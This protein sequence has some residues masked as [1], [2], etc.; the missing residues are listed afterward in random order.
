MWQAQLQGNKSWNLAPTP[1][2]DRQ[3]KSFSFYVEPGDIGRY[4]LYGFLFKIIIK[5]IFILNFILVLIDTRVWYHSTAIM[6][7]E[8]SLTI[9][10][11]YG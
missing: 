5:L 8:F 9:Q 11:E 6:N 7:G 3:C 1:E 4:N 2:C 10:S